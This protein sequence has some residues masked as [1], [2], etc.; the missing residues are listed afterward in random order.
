MGEQK[1]PTVWMEPMTSRLLGRH[2]IHKATVTFNQITWKPN[3]S[4]CFSRVNDTIAL[5]KI[6]L[7]YSA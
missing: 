7:L 1:N 3:N 6:V 2:H 5:R 4:E